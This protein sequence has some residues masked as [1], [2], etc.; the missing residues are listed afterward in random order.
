M[1][2][3]LSLPSFCSIR[4]PVRC[5]LPHEALP[6]PGDGSHRSTHL[7]GAAAPPSASHPPALQLGKHGTGLKGFLF[8]AD[9]AECTESVKLKPQGPHKEMQYGRPCDLCD[10]EVTAFRP[11]QLC[12]SCRPVP[13][14]SLAL[15]LVDVS[16]TQVRT[17]GA[18]R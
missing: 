13:R 15:C 16:G 14:S 2:L 1:A 8:T 6:Q 17:A 18:F 10:L 12:C 7:Q 5:Q 11:R 4:Q 9:R 3:T